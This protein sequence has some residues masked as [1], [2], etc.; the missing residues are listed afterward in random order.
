EHLDHRTCGAGAHPRPGHRLTGS[1]G[2]GHA[3][4]AR[5][6]RP[7]RREPRR[8]RRVPAVRVPGV[9]D[10]LHVLPGPARHPL[11]RPDVPPAG[12]QPRQLPP[13][14]RGRGVP[15]RAADQPGGDAGDGRGGAAVRVP[16]LGRRRSVQV[17]R[18]QGLRADAPGDPD[19]PRRG[20]VHLPVQD[21]RGLAAA[22]HRRRAHPDLR[23]LRPAVHDLDPARLRRRGPVRAGGGR[24]GRRLQSYAGV[25]PHHLPAAG[26]RTRRDRRVRLH[27]GVERVHARPRG[28]EPRGQA[29]A[30]GV[31]EHVHRR[32]PWHR[33]G[34]DHGRLH[35]DRHPGRHLLPA[36]PGPDD[37]R[38]RL[39]RG[40]GV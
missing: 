37:L 26:A 40:E 9:L 5:V 27:P 36:R 25:L 7:G 39:R 22:Q 4:T 34:S 16:R 24:D 28:D 21:A 19:D 18:P 30:A 15:E 1:C 13:A 20:P 2:T 3:A 35:A 38:P 10:G 23:R 17:P 29:D 31:A 6:R 33:L 32:E 11:A 8:H 12:W 14:V